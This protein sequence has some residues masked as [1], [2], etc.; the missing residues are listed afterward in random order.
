VLDANLARSGCDSKWNL[1]CGE[2]GYA[3]SPKLDERPA[4]I[5][6]LL[7]TLV[8]RSNDTRHFPGAE[9]RPATQQA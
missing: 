5:L 2:P 8:N 7:R 3:F 6:A 9:A 4:K 1:S